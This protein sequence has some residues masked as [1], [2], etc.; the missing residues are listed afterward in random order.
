MLFRGLHLDPDQYFEEVGMTHVV[1]SCLFQ[2]ARERLGSGWRVE[3][4]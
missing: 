1:L 4:G 3:I 2:M